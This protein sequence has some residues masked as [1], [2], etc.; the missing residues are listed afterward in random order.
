[1]SLGAGNHFDPSHLGLFLC[2]KWVKNVLCA[3]ISLCSTP[4]AY[5]QPQSGN[6][7]NKALLL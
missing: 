7:G 2:C 6:P 1:M 3:P 5:K 4:W